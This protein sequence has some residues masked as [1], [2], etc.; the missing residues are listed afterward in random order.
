MK[1]TTTKKITTLPKKIESFYPP[2]IV[3]GLSG[4]KYAVFNGTW[5]P[6]PTNMTLQQ[7]RSRWID[8][9]TK[10]MSKKPKTAD[11]IWKVK[12]SKGNGEYTVV[13]DSRGWVCTCAGY[14]FRR[15]CRHIDEIKA[16][17]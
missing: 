14:G 5:Y 6:I 11:W 8:G 4:G 2:A 3:N 16:K 7:V 9:G 10:Y 12:N 13:F 1:T 15:S 17:V